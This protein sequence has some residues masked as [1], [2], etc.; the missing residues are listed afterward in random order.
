MRRYVRDLKDHNTKSAR[1]RGLKKLVTVGL[2]T[3]WP[4]KIVTHAGFVEYKKQ[5]KLTNELKQQILS[6]FCLI[7]EQNPQRGVYAGRAYYVPGVDNPPGP[8]S[9]SVRSQR[10]IL[11]AVEKLYTFAIENKFDKKNGAEIG[12][13]F[14][15]FINAGDPV[16]DLKCPELQFAGG[17]VAPAEGNRAVIEALYGADEGV[18]SFAYDTYIVDLLAMHIISKDIRCKTESLRAT[19]EL[20]YKT[21]KVPV[22]FRD[23]AA[24][25]DEAVISI[26][27]DI[28]KVIRRF[29]PHRLEFIL[30]PE[31]IIFRECVPFK[32]EKQEALAA[33]GE[34]RVVKN[35]ADLSSLD[36]ETS[37][38]FVHPMVITN[39]NMDL[40]TKLAFEVP[41]KY[42]ILFPG[43]A[44]TAHAA[45][46]L[47]ERG[48][49]IVYVGQETFKTGEEISLKAGRII[50]Q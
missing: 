24:L 29:G 27:R 31:G 45:T 30:Q 44:T 50:K 10:V 19:N 8:R 18:Q 33:S 20:T 12:V 42:L 11:Q 14:Y 46:L 21:I 23:K 41:R 47:R 6:A 48:H 39:R 40:L 22:E 1:I 3:P 9:S 5:G 25:S 36:R 32:L 35:D 4:I 26:A 34:V 15:P 7:R 13:I 49:K 2:Q 16:P 38:V 43:S 17:C 28:K 37:I